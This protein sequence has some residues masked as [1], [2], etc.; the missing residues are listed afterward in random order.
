[1]REHRPTP[2]DY[3]PAPAPRTIGPWSSLG[4][5]Y[6]VIL[7]GMIALL[8]VTYIYQIASFPGFPVPTDPPM[9]QPLN[10]YP[11]LSEPE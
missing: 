8:G 1:M 5:V 9:T 4:I 10:P 7:L 11:T 6:G 2:I 3:A